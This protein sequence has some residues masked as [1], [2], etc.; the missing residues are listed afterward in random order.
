MAGIETVVQLADGV[1]DG[2]RGRGGRRGTVSWRGI[3]FAEPPVRQY[4]WRAPRPV[5]P[6]PGVRECYDYGNAP[7]QDKIFTARVRE[8]SSRAVKTA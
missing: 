1:V 2:K 8:S 7:V 6:W 3:P 5:V 4:R